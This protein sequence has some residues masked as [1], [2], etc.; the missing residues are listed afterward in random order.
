MTVNDK[1][2]TQDRLLKHEIIQGSVCKLCDDSAESRNHLFFECKLSNAVWNGIM[3]WLKFKWR[4]CD[5]STLLNWYCFRLKG[6]GFKQKTK[7]M[8]LAAAVY[9]IWRERNNRIFQ[10]KCKTPDAIIKDIKMD[11]FVAILNGSPSA[12]DR[13]WILSL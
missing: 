13:E 11:I 3:E 6:K 12:E 8:A 9:N 10:L 7:R 5:W 4:S 1:L 2:Q